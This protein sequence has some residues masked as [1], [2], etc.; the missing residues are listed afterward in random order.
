[1]ARN[2]LRDRVLSPGALAARARLQEFDRQGTERSRVESTESAG[3][4]GAPGGDVADCVRALEG[5]G[6]RSGDHGASSPGI[7]SPGGPP[8]WRWMGTDRSAAR[9]GWCEQPQRFT[10]VSTGDTYTRRCGAARSSRCVPC[11]A[12]KR[13]DV[14]AIGRS[15]WMGHGGALGYFTT[16]TAPGSDVLPFDRSK[17]SHSDGVKCSGDVG[18]VC[19][20]V[21]LDRWHDGIGLR[22]SHFV[23]DIR[24][25]L[26]RRWPG[27]TVEFCKTWEA[28]HRGALHAHAM[29]R[30]SGAPVSHR[31][32]RAAVRLCA[33]RNGFGRRF[34]VQAVDLSDSRAVAMTAGYVAKYAAKNA[35]TLPELRRVDVT[36]RCTVGGVRAWSSSRKWG[37]SMAVV[38]ARRASW[39]A[40]G[41]PG[42]VS[43]SAG[44]TPALGGAAALDLKSGIYAQA[45]PDD[46]KSGAV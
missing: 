37:D 44:G 30:V 21:A 28:Q 19:D 27:V 24:R 6:R 23:T 29:V 14:A 41:G 34:D 35:D 36:G 25:V 22:W 13:G 17:C 26:A 8:C 10:N 15:G 32:F 16:L 46:L 5:S 7:G 39:F 4:G 1:M 18:C 42:G 11:A 20:A 40:A 3:H 45:P 9:D 31:A 2:D 12:L 38:Q 43:S 33:G